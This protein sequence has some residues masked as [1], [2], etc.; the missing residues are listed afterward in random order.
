VLFVG[1]VV[2]V[3]ESETAAG[4]TGPDAPAVLEMRDTRMNYGG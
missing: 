4:G 1:E 2:G 3:G